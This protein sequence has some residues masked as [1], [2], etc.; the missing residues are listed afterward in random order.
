MLAQ[1][2]AVHQ[3]YAI[4]RDVMALY[5]PVTPVIQSIFLNIDFFGPL[6]A[7]R[8]ANTAFIALTVFFIAD[9]GR[10]C[11]PQWRI[12]L[13]ASRAS[14]VTWVILSDVWL[15]VTMLPWPSVLAG[16]FGSASLYFVAKSQSSSLVL[17][18]KLTLLWGFTAGLS[19]GLGPF[20][21]LNIGLA[22]LTSTILIVSTLAFAFPKVW[23]KTA[24]TVVIGT[25]TSAL[26]VLLF[27]YFTN[28]ISKYYTQAIKWPSELA[29]EAIEDWKPK[30]NIFRILSE[31]VLQASSLIL[32]SLFQNRFSKS[33]KVAIWFVI[34]VGLFASEWFLALRN[35]DKKSKELEI[36]F[37]ELRHELFIV[38]LQFFLVLVFI[39]IFVVTLRVFKLLLSKSFSEILNYSG[40]ILLSSLNVS[41]A[42][43]VV[44]TWDSRHISW[45][46]PA[47]LLLFLSIG[48][49][50]Q[51]KPK[52]FLNPIVI[53][54]M[55]VA[56]LALSSGISNLN[57]P[58]EPT[59]VGQSIAKGMRLSAHEVAWLAADSDF[60]KNHLG[61]QR[62]AIFLTWN[63]YLSV[64]NGPYVS[65]D[66]YFT[67][68]LD[69]SDLSDRLMKKVPIVIEDAILADE[70]KFLKIKEDL[71]FHGYQ[72]VAQNLHLFIFKAI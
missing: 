30:E 61:V 36:T 47:G 59:I 69:H 68:M 10:I 55:F 41:L 22:S 49:N 15:G 26:S 48:S 71:D 5:G 17:N 51:K 7:L 53:Q 6:L 4:H 67:V 46:L 37:T 23:K 16:L 42:S 60:L 1:A 64:I 57:A 29:P 27:L 20:T 31:Q 28:S 39:S 70:K 13:S 66:E 34:T 18:T 44:P 12:S 65:Y 62:K 63:G 33:I 24:V 58:R 38:Y 2:V 32:F 14:A 3:G 56:L 50:V 52:I 11:P 19:L 35:F 43:Q 25:L 72:L 9:L 54:I 21:K 8:F 45:A 40:L